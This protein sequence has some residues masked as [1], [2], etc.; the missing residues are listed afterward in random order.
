[1]VKKKITID[2][3]L[4][5]LG[6]SEKERNAFHECITIV[7]NEQNGTELDSESE[8]KRII[9]EVIENEV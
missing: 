5:E 3:V 6:F 9:S 8:I 1:M 4:N 2:D 7:K